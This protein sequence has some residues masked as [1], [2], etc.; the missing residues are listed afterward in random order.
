MLRSMSIEPEPISKAIVTLKS[1]RPWGVA[2]MIRR[3]RSRGVALSAARQK[4]L[5]GSFHSV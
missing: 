3:E 4:V 5:L 2:R 1:K